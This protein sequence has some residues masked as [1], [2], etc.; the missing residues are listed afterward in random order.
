[1]TTSEN[2]YILF[3]D[4][5]TRLSVRFWAKLLDMYTGSEE[6]VPAVRV[7]NSGFRLCTSLI[8]RPMIVVFGLGTRLHVRMHTK[9]DGAIMRHF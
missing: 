8:P 2:Y 3:F 6:T 5:L 9:S 7:V 4:D 1:M